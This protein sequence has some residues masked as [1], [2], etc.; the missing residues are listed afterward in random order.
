M[1][2]LLPPSSWDLG[3]EH[4]RGLKEE[5]KTNRE[6]QGGRGKRERNTG[7]KRGRVQGHDSGGGGGKC[8]LSPGR[9]A[10]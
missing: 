1:R 3:A 5:K 9:N 6:T 7:R 10:E 2:C 8:N 4:R